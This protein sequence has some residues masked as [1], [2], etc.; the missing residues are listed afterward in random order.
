[1]L[2]QVQNQSHLPHTDSQATRAAAPH[3]LMRDQAAHATGSH[4]PLPRK[5]TRATQT[6]MQNR[7]YATQTHTQMSHLLTRAIQLVSSTD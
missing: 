1:M 5:D 7:S 4:L 3:R 2:G 6:I